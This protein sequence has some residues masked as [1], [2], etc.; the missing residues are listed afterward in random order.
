MVYEADPRVDMYIDA[1]PEWQQKIC[2]EVRELIHEADPEVEET[3]KRSVQPYFVLDGNVCALLAAKNHVNVFLYDGAIVPDRMGSSPGD[4]TIRRPGPWLQ[5]ERADQPSRTAAHVQGS[6]REQPRRRMATAEGRC[7]SDRS[8]LTD[9]FHADYAARPGSILTVC[10][11]YSDGSPTGV[12]S[13]P[14]DG[15]LCGQSSWPYDPRD[16]DPGAAPADAPPEF[17]VGPPSAIPAVTGPP[18]LASAA[19]DPRECARLT[20]L[21]PR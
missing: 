11:I 17:A 6:H 14:A 4:T 20:I 1:L 21:E 10:D 13:T 12:T 16:A 3:I 7:A 5:G 2:R 8:R 19:S 18:G 15:A 9:V